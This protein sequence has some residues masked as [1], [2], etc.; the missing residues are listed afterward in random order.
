MFD[1]KQYYVKTLDEKNAKIGL[2]TQ[3]ITLAPGESKTLDFLVYYG[4]QDV[5]TLA[6]FDMGFE[7]IVNYAIGGFFDL[8]AFKQTDAIAK[9]MM[10]YI[11]L[12]HKVVRNWGLAIILFALSI[13]GFTY[14]LTKKTM[15]S[16]KKLQ[17]HQPK[18]AKIKEKHKNNPQKMQKETME[19]Y[20]KYKINPLGGCLPMLLQM[21]IFI[22]LYQ[23]LWRS[24]TFKGAGF[25]WINDLS[26]PDRLFTLPFTLPYFG[27]E[28]NILP[29]IYGILMFF[30]QKFQSKSMAGGDPVQV[31]TQQMMAKIF[32]VM[33]G[34]IF[35]KFASGLTL[36]FTTYF[37]CTA[38]AQWRMS[39]DKGAVSG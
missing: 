25:L 11:A 32:P 35:Y 24:Y 22:S 36:Y 13:Y 6:S 28:L 2:R 26:E 21:P 34:V 9:I 1:A 3:E 37:L 38:T 30:Q 17:D 8:M 23:L 39:R 16:M 18:L 29:I 27:N 19:Y 5:K 14:P 33:L 10:K 12:L 4:P 31:Q 15:T 7:K 20:K